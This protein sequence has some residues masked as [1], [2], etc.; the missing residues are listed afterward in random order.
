MIPPGRAPPVPHAGFI[1]KFTA[2]ALGASMWF[3]VCASQS[4][5]SVG[6]IVRFGSIIANE[7]LQLMYRAKKDGT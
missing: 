7:V 6:L 5:C 2:K 4:P 3:F 1:Y